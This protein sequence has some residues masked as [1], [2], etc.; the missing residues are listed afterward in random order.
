VATAPNAESVEAASQAHSWVVDNGV[1][2]P[3]AEQDKIFQ[4]NFST[5]TS[6]TG[7]GLAIARKTIRELDGDIGFHTQED[8]GTT[9]WIHLPLTE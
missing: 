8:E 4:P 7:L 1:G 6:G 3:P 5:K 2:I 9:F